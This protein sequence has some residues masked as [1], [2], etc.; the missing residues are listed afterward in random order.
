MLGRWGFLPIETI[1]RF[2]E[3]RPR[4]AFPRRGLDLASRE[5]IRPFAWHPRWLDLFR[6]PGGDALCVDCVPG[7]KG[8]IGQLILVSREDPDL[9]LVASS[10]D[11]FFALIASD[12]AR[13]GGQSR[14][15]EWPV[16][17]G[18]P[19][20]TGGSSS[21]GGGENALVPPKS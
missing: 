3:R 11:E 18:M 17:R 8:K 4:V 7:P 6:D 9:L 12:W 1:L 19:G 20:E 13:L 14:L 10:L 2:Y 5:A 15:T 16:V 21:A